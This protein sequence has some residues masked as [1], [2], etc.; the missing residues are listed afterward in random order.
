MPLRYPMKIPDGLSGPG[1][2]ENHFYTY[3]ERAQQD[4]PLLQD[5]GN[6]QREAKDIAPTLTMIV[7]GPEHRAG[8][9]VPCKGKSLE[10]TQDEIPQTESQID[11]LLN[12]DGN[13][14]MLGLDLGIN[15]LS[16]KS[17]ETPEE[18]YKSHWGKMNTKPMGGK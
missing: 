10:R 15:S 5:N 4:L 18:Q 12:A 16:Y 17:I 6:S 1:G 13:L 2:E 7:H 11:V 14:D 9:S 3:A 8:D